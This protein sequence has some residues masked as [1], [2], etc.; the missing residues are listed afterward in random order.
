MSLIINRG[1]RLHVH[2]GTGFPL[3]SSKQASIPFLS[4]SISVLMSVL[5]IF[6]VSK[7][8]HIK[9]SSTDYE[10]IIYA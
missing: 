2:L 10:N 7:I 6:V 8:N 9:T 5:I 3:F 4:Y 1:K